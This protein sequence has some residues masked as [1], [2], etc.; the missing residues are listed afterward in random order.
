M[1]K[2][3]INAKQTDTIR[4]YGTENN[5]ISFPPKVEFEAD[6][7]DYEIKT[8]KADRIDIGVFPEGDRMELAV[9]DGSTIILEN[10]RIKE[11]IEIDGEGDFT[12]DISKVYGRIDV[13]IINGTAQ[14]FIEADYNFNTIVKGSG[15]SI[16]Y[17]NCKINP[18]SINGIELNGRNCKLVI[19]TKKG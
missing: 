15:N 12:I 9:S 1:L 3:E 2:Y 5:I 16:R 17:D 6:N 4:V 10:L 11:R 7:G 8:P 18:Q 14:L 13:N 19:T